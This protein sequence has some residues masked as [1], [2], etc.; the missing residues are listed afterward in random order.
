MA[1]PPPTASDSPRSHP[2]VRPIP[3]AFRRRA[4]RHERR[5]ELAHR[6]G[7]ED[8]GRAR[9]FGRVALDHHDGRGARRAN[10][11]R[12]LLDR[13]RDR[14]RGHRV[15]PRDH[16]TLR[17]A[18]SQRR[19]SQTGNGG[20]SRRRRYG[21]S[22]R[23]PCHWAGFAPGLVRSR[24]RAGRRLRS[25]PAPRSPSLRHQRT[26]SSR[27]ARQCFSPPH[28]GAFGLLAPGPPRRPHRSHDRAPRE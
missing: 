17:R 25:R 15:P 11:E 18:Q 9:S 10:R 14:L 7:A 22:A 26:R 1:R 24:G 27:A 13:P 16:W 28:R 12:A 4:F 3:A 2:L 19:Q 6:A 20:A 23:A 21:R 5:S 8:R